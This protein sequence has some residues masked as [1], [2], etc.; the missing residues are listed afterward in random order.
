ML[1]KVSKLGP[2]V[3][4]PSAGH[5]AT[6]CTMDSETWWAESVQAA[7]VG[8]VLEP[9]DKVLL[10]SLVLGLGGHWSH[11]SNVQRPRGP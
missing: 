8:S 6:S 1:F 5:T 10:G 2:T 7:P 4:V 3:V 11:C 9:E